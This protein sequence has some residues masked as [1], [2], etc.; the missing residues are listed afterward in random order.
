AEIRDDLTTFQNELLSLL[1]E[2]GLE[3]PAERIDLGTTYVMIQFWARL[4]GHI[5]LEV[6]G[7]YP[8]PMSKP[9]AVFDALLADLASQTGLDT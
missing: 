3:V 6:F 1:R 4:Y 9:D 7:N 8:L 2:T 5:T